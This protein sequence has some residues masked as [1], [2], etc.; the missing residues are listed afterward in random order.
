MGEDSATAGVSPAGRSGPLWTADFLIVLVCTHLAF[1]SFV[2]TFTTL[3]LYLEDADKWQIG[4]VVGSMG[5]AGMFMRPLAGLWADRY[6]RRLFMVIGAGAT[7]LGLAAC[8]L[9][10]DPYLL[11]PLR[12]VN[13]AGMVLFITAAF[14]TVADIVP[15]D[16]RGVA[17]GY[18]AM[19]NSLPQIYAPWLGL[20]IA[21]TWGFTP[22][23]LTAAVVSGLAFLLSSRINDGRGAARAAE[24]LSAA[25]LVSRSTLL[26]ASL[27]LSLT[28]AFGAIQAFLPLMAEDRD[29]GN[30]GLFFV[31]YGVVVVPLRPVVGA[32]ADRYGRA[33]V[34]VPGLVLGG[35]AM[36]LLATASMQGVMLAAAVLFGL[37]FG[38]AHTA[39]LA[40]TV[41][42]ADTEQRGVAMSTFGLAWDTGSGVGALT[43]GLMAGFVSYGGVFAMAG[44]LPL[45]A[46]MLFVAGSRLPRRG[47]PDTVG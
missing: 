17:F 13:G 36:L 7:S 33:V 31:L 32:L 4:L 12:M 37:G 16:R 1:A 28:V 10:D 27:F 19:M 23:F 21:R 45:A 46:S 2:S 24:G 35:L 25:A 5:L 18:L 39:L 22:Y 3:P 9:S 26:P 6:G 30:P 47:A 38:G 15:A 11:L 44:A 34:F 42:R 43:F 29:L 40:W 14:A 20:T 41:D 8:A